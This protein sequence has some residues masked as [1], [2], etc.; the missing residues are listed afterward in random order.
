MYAA[1]VSFVLENILELQT[2]AADKD[3]SDIAEST[4]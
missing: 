4:V 2:K 1:A 3:K